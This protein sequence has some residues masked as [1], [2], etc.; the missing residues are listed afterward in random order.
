ML[1]PPQHHHRCHPRLLSANAIREPGSARMHWC[2]YFAVAIAAVS[3]LPLQSNAPIVQLRREYCTSGACTVSAATQHRQALDFAP[4]GDRINH[5]LVVQL[6]TVWHN[7]RMYGYTGEQFELAADVLKVRLVIR[8]MLRRRDDILKM[9][10]Q[11]LSRPLPADHELD[12]ERVEV[13]MRQHRHAFE[14][15]QAQRLFCEMDREA[16]LPEHQVK[17]RMDDRRRRHFTGG[18]GRGGDEGSSL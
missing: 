5:G 17:K 7:F 16:K 2:D 12:S 6:V 15:S 8:D 10:G 11:A 14:N 13:Y 18:V 4:H 1:P 9:E 3:L